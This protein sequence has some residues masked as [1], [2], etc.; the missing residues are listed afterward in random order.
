MSRHGADAD[1]VEDAIQD[2]LMGG[3]CYEPEDGKLTPIDAPSRGPSLPCAHRARCGRTASRRSSGHSRHRRRATAGGGRLSRRHRSRTRYEGV[4]LQSAAE[5]RRE[6]L[7]TCLR[8][9]RADRLVVIGD[10]GHAIG[11]PFADERAELETLFDALTC[12]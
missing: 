4:E 2:A 10:L 5:A 7:L 8:R 11:D 1:A 9:A 6:R 3:R 12:P